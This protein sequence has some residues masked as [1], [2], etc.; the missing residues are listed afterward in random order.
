MFPRKLHPTQMHIQIHNLKGVIF[1]L[2]L[3]TNFGK[4]KFINKMNVKNN[5]QR[6]FLFRSW[7]MYI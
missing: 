4:P 1:T 6:L 5:M 2:F 3:K 7:H